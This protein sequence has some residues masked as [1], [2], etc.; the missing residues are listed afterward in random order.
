MKQ[1]TLGSTGLRVGVIGMGTWQ[2][3]GEWDK[4]FAQAEVDQMFDAA[5]DTGINLI[6]TAECYGDH[7]SEQFIG[8]ATQRDRGTWVLCTKFGHKYRGMMQRDEPRQPSD[9]RVQLE[10]S[11]KAL[12]TDYVDVL[13][14]H[15]W[16]DEFWDDDVLAVLHEAKA[17]GKVRHLGNSVRNN[18]SAED[19]AKH[20]ATSR[21]R[22]IE[23]IQIVYNRLDRAPETHGFAACQEQNLGVLARVPMASGY[24]SGK[25]HPG[26][27]A[28]FGEGD[29]RAG[30]DKK[31][32]REKLENVEKIMNNE[33][34]EGVPMPQWALAWC[35]KHPAVSVV[36]P[37]VKTV[38][39]VKSNAAAGDLAMIPDDHPHAAR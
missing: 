14:Y 25:Y 11:L 13:Q 30:H 2:F 7:V 39:Q 16:G 28:K 1:R 22:G 8:A 15:S 20:I 4:Q 27:E 10:D 9:V 38:E 3:G 24:L 21:E 6:D 26:D 29:V 36:I 32:V 17:A 5:R 12:R 34:P 31:D 18:K 19:N 33:V 35:L 37:G 23:V